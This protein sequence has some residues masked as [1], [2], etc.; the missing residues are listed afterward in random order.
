MLRSTTCNSINNKEF[1]FG[2]TVFHTH[3][4]KWY[5]CV[6]FRINR[7]IG[8][9]SDEEYLCGEKLLRLEGLGEF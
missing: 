7:K 2:S 8:S 1:T 6:P 4:P 5:Y 3:V 9:Y